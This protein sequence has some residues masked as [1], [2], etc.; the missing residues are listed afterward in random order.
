MY[1]K[2][3][4]EEMR[5]S[6][7]FTKENFGLQIGDGYPDLVREI[8]KSD[9]LTGRLLIGLIT[10]SL[11]GREL[12]LSMKEGMTENRL[13]ISSVILQNI[14]DM[15]LSML[16]WGIQIGRKLEQESAKSLAELEKQGK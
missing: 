3:L 8:V 14:G 12:A 7:Q 9:N 1:L 10:S 4:E 15:P 2:M 11:S 6:D 16:Y 5:T 13:D